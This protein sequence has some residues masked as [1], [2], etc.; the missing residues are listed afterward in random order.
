VPR[1]RP[2]VPLL[3]IWTV[4]LGSLLTAQVIGGVTQAP[5]RD[6]GVQPPNER[7]IPVGTSSISGTVVAAD[8]GRP[9][10]GVRVIVSGTVTAN[11]AASGSLAAQAGRGALPVGIPTQPGRGGGQ[12]ILTTMAGQVMPSIPN[13]SASSLSRAAITDATGSFSF[14]RLPAGH[15][16][17]SAS[18][19]QFL[20]VAYGQT[21]PG[22][23][24]KIIALVD[25][26]QITLNV[27][28]P[29]GGVIT[30]MVVGAEGDPQ[31][32]A[33]VR[34]WRV[35]ISGGFKRLVSTSSAQSDDRG[36]YRIFGLQPGEYFVSATPSP[37]EFLI[38]AQMSAQTD[39]VERAIATAPVI[40]PAA[41]GM[42]PTVAVPIPTP[43]TGNQVLG[44][45]PYLP[46]YA[47]SSMAPSGATSVTVAAGEE[48]MGVDVRLQM[49]QSSNIQGV[50]TTPLDA[51]VTLQLSLVSDD[52]TIDSPQ[53]MSSRPD[54]T[55]AFTFRGVAP[56]TYTVVG[57]TT[58]AQP[59][60]TI[61]N[62]QATSPTQPP[63]ALTDAQ[64]MWGRARVTVAGEVT[65]PVSLTLKPGRSISGVVAFDMA[66]PPDL[67]RTRVMVSIT[68]APSPQPIFGGTV[69]PAQVSPDGRFTI[70]GV[71]P[72]R[73][74][75]RA[76]N[77]VSKSAVV[78]GVDTLDFPMDFSGDRDVTD[79]VI[80]VTDQISELSGSLMDSAGKPAVGYTIIAVATD[81]RHWL[82][83]SRR[84][85]MGRPGP[86]GQY[87]IRGLP[88]G[89]Y[90]LAA[91][92][93]LVQGEQYDPE[94]LRTIA[95]ASV[96]VTIVDGGKVTQDLRVK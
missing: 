42:T 69:T 63:A 83:G 26:Q 65:I 79:A 57:Q 81:N 91:V 59:T 52:L 35:D 56:G 25:G 30:G 71:M 62:G 6:S 13:A 38:A 88:A 27:S 75:L 53:T 89:T 46:T 17:V 3:A 73:Y 95:R 45:Q 33:Q 39:L 43:P 32:S 72:G 1:I 20:Q 21:R 92:V 94:F 58:P 68:P 9:V 48:R 47:P 4:S 8:T 96:P 60:I 93:D 84:I 31:R 10:A 37:G 7:R 40:P 23:Q 18:Q 78:S 36:I 51:G 49:V 28:L 64:K 41:A 2:I 16:T 29:R 82:P 22:G 44:S 70:T 90:Q 77:G 24:G 67:T 14:P 55:G 34:S 61:V 76:S 50:L 12:Q 86:D 74:T 5:P 54:A 66:R 85:A 87:A 80:T 19:T 11:A 15:F